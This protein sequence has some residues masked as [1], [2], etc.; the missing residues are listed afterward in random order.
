MFCPITNLYRMLNSI[1]SKRIMDSNCN[2]V[3]DTC[4]NHKN[5]H[6][7]N[8]VNQGKQPNTNNGPGSIF[9]SKIKLFRICQK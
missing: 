2:C 7:T 6:M 8:I 9:M 5:N 3:W 4:P 1:A